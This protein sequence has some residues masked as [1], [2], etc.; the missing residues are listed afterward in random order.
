MQELLAHGDRRVVLARR[1]FRFGER[2][3]Q[4][5]LGAVG[6]G[7]V[8]VVRRARVVRQRESQ[9]GV[10]LHTARR[11]ADHLHVAVAM[12]QPIHAVATLVDRVLGAGDREVAHA[13]AAAVQRNLDAAARGEQD[14][15]ARCIHGKPAGLHFLHRR[16]EGLAQSVAGTGLQIAWRVQRVGCIEC[17]GVELGCRHRHAAPELVPHMRAARGHVARVVPGAQGRAT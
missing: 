12:R 11:E 6:L 17:N 13:T 16:A 7:V 14:L 15:A 8:T 4:P 10:R 9:Q 2:H 1:D 3:A 5:L